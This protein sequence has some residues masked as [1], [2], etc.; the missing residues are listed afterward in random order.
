MAFSYPHKSRQA[1]RKLLRLGVSGPLVQFWIIAIAGFVFLVA[2]GPVLFANSQGLPVMIGV[3]AYALGV[4]LAGWSLHRFYPHHVLGLCNAVTIFRMVLVAVLVS[5]LFSGA[6]NSWG[7]F[8]VAAAALAL[9]GVDGWL[10]RRA[11]LVSSFGARFDM[12]VDSAL[13]LVL[14]ILAFVSGSAGPLV[15]ILG[16]PRY[17]FAGAGLIFP[18]L[19]APLP[20]RFSR[21]AVC[22]L[23]LA[24]LIMLQLPFL[25]AMAANLCVVIAVLALIWSFERDVVWLRRRRT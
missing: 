3:G 22:V 5:T 17:V 4:A 8:L 23:Q 16:V 6:A 9:D 12:E 18:W 19:N 7:V 13:A 20:E 11:N 21:K 24:T 14:A 15:L 1:R 25:P 2:V 10:A